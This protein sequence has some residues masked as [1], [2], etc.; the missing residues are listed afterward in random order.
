MAAAA[1]SPSRAALLS[2]NPDLPGAPRVLSYAEYEELVDVLNR[3]DQTEVAEAVSGLRRLGG[4]MSRTAYLLAVQGLPTTVLKIANVDDA[5]Y[6]N[7]TEVSCA[8][9]SQS[10]L[11]PEIFD[12]GPSDYDVAWLEVEYLHPIDRVDFYDLTGVPAAR[13]EGILSGR[14][15]EAEARLLAAATSASESGNTKAADFLTRLAELIGT[16]DLAPAD[17]LKQ[18]HWAV[19]AQDRLKFVDFGYRRPKHRFV[20]PMDAV[21]L[22]PES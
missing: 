16:C 17:L 20:H 6:Q 22:L 5:Y 8:L 1:A 15:E 11:L 13:L 12:W 21:V 2:W 4:G 9:R 14:S 3:G 10:P 19:D 7:A 18:E